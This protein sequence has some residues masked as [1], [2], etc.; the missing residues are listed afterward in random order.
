MVRT[1]LLTLRTLLFPRQSICERQELYFRADQGSV[2]NEAGDYL[3]VNG[4]AAFDTYFNT[5]PAVKY[6]EYCRLSSLFLRL[7]LSGSF[8]VHVY[9][10]NRNEGGLHEQCVLEC[11][12]R[13]AEESGVELDLTEAYTGY[14][15]LYFTLTSRGGRLYGG[16]FAGACPQKQP[17]KMAV[18]I[19]T[20]RREQYL[21][22]NHAAIC[23]YL[24]RSTFFD[25]ETIHFYIVDNGRTLRREE[26][27]TPYF[28]LLPNDNTGGSGGF[29]RGYYE[30]VHS[31]E[32]YTHI[33]FMDDDIILDGD[34]LLRV[35]ALLQTRRPEFASL[36]VGGTMLKASDRIT[37]HEA[38]AVWDGKRIHSI[39]T[40]CRMVSREAVFDVAYY[41]RGNYQA[42]W[43]YCFPAEWQQEYGYPLQFFIKVDDIEY[44]LRCAGEIAI[45]SGIAVWHDD[46]DDKYDGFQEY[47]IK[48]NELIVTCVNQQKPYAWYQLRKLLLSVIKQTVYQRYFLV[49][50]VLRAYDDFLKGWE[51][52]AKT[53]TAALNREIMQSCQ[54]LLTD[55]Q[56][57]EQ[58]GVA[59]DEEKY[60]L[61]R[62][63]PENRKIQALSGNGYLIP[64][65]FYRKDKDGYAITDLARCRI[66]NFYK[67]KRVLHYDVTRRK[68]FVTVQ[69]KWKLYSNL[70]RVVGKSVKFLIRYPS[71][72]RG[73]REHL[74]ELAAFEP[75]PSSE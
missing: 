6:R 9:G 5:L 19:C 12:Y 25:P 27:E 22:R 56:L 33:L 58:Y 48:R 52:F 37:Q 65:V 28:T 75:K 8:A 31:G 40:D 38:G 21:L 2:W 11:S 23:A 15:S 64:Y 1:D 68:G 29:T 41:P 10:V 54:P 7:R 72:R 67:H 51:Y 71:V 63:E 60:Q 43:F 59:F 36:S 44:S 69:K 57:L 30:A 49:D 74:S 46:F 47:Y 3:I 24:E 62:T 50:L 18:V 73:F 42:W 32:A 20:F 4:T 14:D 16:E 13:T 35:A 55:E 53:D 26:I 39:G 17:V 70:C 45:I 34:M 66:V 61:S